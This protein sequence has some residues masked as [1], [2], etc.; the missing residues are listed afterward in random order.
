MKLILGF[1]LTVL[2][3]G[4]AWAQFGPP[5]GSSG[6]PLTGCTFTGA[7]TPQT[8]G[9][10]VGTTLAN[11]ANAGSIGEVVSST[12]AVGSAVSMVTATPKTV[13]SVSLTAGDWEC[14]G[15]VDLSGT[16][17]TTVLSSTSGIGGTTNVLPG[18]PN[19]LTNFYLNQTVLGGAV[20]PGILT[21]TVREN[22]S[23]TTTVFLVNQSSFAVSTLSTYGNLSCIRER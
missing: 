21:P 10:L 23:T 13:T 1:L 7:V 17:T 19:Q 16:G 11:N 20:A 9:G 12:I 14:Y 8:T 22:V 2:L 6:C 3:N 4:P 15:I 18:D 5:G